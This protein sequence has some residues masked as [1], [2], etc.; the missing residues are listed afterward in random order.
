M[1]SKAVA[2]KEAGA[3]STY[4][5]GDDAGSGFEDVR[6]DEIVVPFISVLQANS[7]Q[8]E[9]KSPPGA[10]AGMFFNTV[11][12]EVHSSIYIQPVHRS[13]QVVEWTPREKGGGIVAR[14]DRDDPKIRARTHTEDGQKIFGKV[15][16]EDGDPEEVNGLVE[17]FYVYG[18]L[19]SED[20]SETLG[21]G[22]IPF[23]S[24]KL[25]P[26]H[27]WWSAMM[28]IKGRPPLIAN[29]ARL[30]TEKQKNNKGQSFYNIVAEPLRDDWLSSLIDPKGEATL[31]EDANS[32]KKMLEDGAAR[33]DFD[34]EASTGSS[35]EESVDDKVF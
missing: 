14:W 22:C 5:Y 18:L 4:D 11:T 29:R 35:D 30:S 3:V 20:G 26:M 28:Q 9:D 33:A 1:S 6:P 12:R 23:S 15:L 10:E 34:N 32:F 24:T 2:K 8:V 17:T 7:P 21:F 31:L 27:K 13:V 16:M 25:T 19:L